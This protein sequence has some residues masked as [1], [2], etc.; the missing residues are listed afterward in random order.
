MGLVYYQVDDE[1][2]HD[3]VSVLTPVPGVQDAVYPLVYLET[4]WTDNTTTLEPS[5]K[6]SRLFKM[7]CYK[8]AVMLYDIAFKQGKARLSVD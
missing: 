2:A 4:T 1:F 3:P 6:L 5:L 8:I 7:S